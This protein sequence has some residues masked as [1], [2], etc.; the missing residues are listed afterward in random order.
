[1]R[2]RS[3]GMQ[4]I[5]SMVVAAVLSLILQGA[6][7]AYLGLRNQG[8]TCYMNSLLQTLHHLPEF[9]ASIYG[10]PTQ[11]DNNTATEVVPLE[12]LHT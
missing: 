4:P 3:G 7:A 1:M 12:L 9:R 10:L 11:L 8:N 5:S 2:S 6:S